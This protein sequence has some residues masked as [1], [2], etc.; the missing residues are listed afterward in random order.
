MLE[1]VGAV[2][3]PPGW[4]KPV[5]ERFRGLRPGDP[6]DEA[7]TLAPV[8]SERAADQLMDQ[9]RDARRPHRYHARGA[10]LQRGAVRPGRHD[11]PLGIHEF[12]IRRFVVT[13]PTYAVIRDA[14]G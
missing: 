5:A 14:L 11:L 10:R 13:M 7:T 2:C 12:A 3:R 1:G 9:V 6:D 8:S 4:G